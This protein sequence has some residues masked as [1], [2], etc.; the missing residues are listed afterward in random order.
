MCLISPCDSVGKYKYDCM[1]LQRKPE[2]QYCFTE[3]IKK[4]KLSRLYFL[5]VFYVLTKL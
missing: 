2:A 1:C 3:I 4:D 5:R